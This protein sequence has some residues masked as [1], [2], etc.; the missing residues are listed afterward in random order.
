[1]SKYHSKKIKRDGITF[2]SVREYNRWCELQ[3]LEK[4][5]K[6]YGLRRQVKFQLIPAQYE[7]IWDKKLHCLKKGKC[8]E[9]ECNYIA[10]FCYYDENGDFIVEDAKGFK[11]PE[12]RIKR[13]LMLHV[14]NKRIVEV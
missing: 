11:T 13:K 3:L 8:I 6:I 1:M 12:Y 9:R 5:G 4:A 2:D 14:H 7:Q 10:D